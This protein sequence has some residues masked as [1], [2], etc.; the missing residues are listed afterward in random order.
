MFKNG[1]D[2]MLVLAKAMLALMIGFILSIICGIILIPLLKKNKAKQTMS[3]FLKEKHKKKEGTP[4]MG[5]FIFIIPTVITVIILLLTNK[6][7]WSNN[8]FIILFVFLSYGLIGFIDDYL[9]IKRKNNIG[10]TE[11][12]KIVGQLVIAL[13]TFYLLMKSGH[14]PQLYIYSLGIK[15]HMAWFY[16]IFLLFILVAS[17]NAVNITDG[18]DGLAGGLSLIVFLSLG[19]ITWNT[20]WLVGHEEIAIFCFILV[21]SLLGFLFFNTNPAKVFMGDVG[22]LSLGATMAIIAVLTNH[23]ITFIIL[24]GVFII[25]TLVCIIQMSSIMIRHKKVF[26]MTPLHHHFEKLGWEERDI[27]KVFWVVGL[28][29]AMVGIL[30]AVWM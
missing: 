14:E 4:T 7:E 11:F 6:L 24:A 26:L 9:I 10:L 25:E 30:F 20:T 22:S 15:I 5:G 19:L 27:V 3:I 1:D 21:G 8:L 16:G 29:L 23:E 12:Q 17:S 28:L 13:I 2:N 18:L